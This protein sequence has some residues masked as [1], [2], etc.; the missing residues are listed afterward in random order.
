M[1]DEI[2]TP[3]DEMARLL[4]RWGLPG[5]LLLGVGGGSSMYGL[6]HTLGFASAEQVEALTSKVEA[7][8]AE[9]A[10]QREKLGHLEARLV[11]F[12]AVA[13]VQ[14]QQVLDGLD[15]CAPEPRR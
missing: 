7:L 8:T 1:S 15:E 4:K 13:Q 12:Q 10:L 5:L 3:Q 6:A 2:L 14:H 11:A 9:T